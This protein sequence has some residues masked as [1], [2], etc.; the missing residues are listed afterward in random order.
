MPDDHKLHYKRMEVPKVKSTDS[1]DQKAVLRLAAPLAY[2][3]L[4][5]NLFLAGGEVVAASKPQGDGTRTGTLLITLLLM[6]S[7]P[8]SLIAGPGRSVRRGSARGVTI[9]LVGSVWATVTTS[10]C[11]ITG[12]VG[13]A[14]TMLPPSSPMSMSCV[15]PAVNLI[16]AALA[17][18][19][20]F[21]AIRF[22][23]KGGTPGLLDDG[24]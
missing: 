21:H 14:R 5:V 22:L 15:L 12:A 10:L 23:A 9:T 3:L 17:G 16:F 20:C 19:L 11:V 6:Y 18:K 24:E 7:V 4:S 2:A 13:L 8:A 1:E